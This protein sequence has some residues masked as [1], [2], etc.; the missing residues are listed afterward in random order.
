[1]CL[2]L[3]LLTYK[4]FGFAAGHVDEIGR[5]LGGW[6]RKESS[7]S[8]KEVVNKAS[9]PRRGSGETAAEPV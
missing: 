6:I 2:G 5:M 1:V 8:K 7:A 9:N 3:K 4:Q